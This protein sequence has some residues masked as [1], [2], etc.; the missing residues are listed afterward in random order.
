MNKTRVMPNGL[1][2]HELN[3]HE[4][5][6]L[7]KEIFADQIYSPADLAEMPPSPII[8]DVG[9]NIGL[10][11]L[12]AAQKWP[13]ARVCC[14]EPAPRTFDVLR[15]NV[16]HLPGSQVHQ[17]ALGSVP[18]QRNLTFYPRYSMMSGFDADPAKDRA[19]VHAYIRNL[20][21][22]IRDEAR[23]DVLLEEADELLIGRFDEVESLPCRV[24]RLDTMAGLLGID[25][26]DL[27]KID[28]EGFEFEVL[29]G[30]GDTLW[31]AVRNVVVEVEG[32]HRHRT[33]VRE[34]LT[35]HGLRNR[36]EQPADYQGTD[37][38]TLVATRT[39]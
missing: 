25:R 1:S 6:Y 30:I 17:I 20:A 21:A 15:R 16:E 4:T 33:A 2:V 14:F 10:F 37:V 28:V 31:G 23:R 26:I 24:E 8:V 12:F 11:A 9:A 18:E 19:L 7:Y 29:N 34:T 27:L 5:D 13:G 22:G 39:G 32:D 38:F 35:R 36:L 3:R